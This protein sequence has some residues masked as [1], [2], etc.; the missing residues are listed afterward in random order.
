[1]EV[2]GISCENVFEGIFIGGVHAPILLSS[3]LRNNA[4]AVHMAFPNRLR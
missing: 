3:G 1:V 4:V 2:E